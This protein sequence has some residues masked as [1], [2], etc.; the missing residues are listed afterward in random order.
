MISVYLLDMIK[1]NRL[2]VLILFP[3]SLFI[4]AAPSSAKIVSRN[5]T[6][7]T[8]AADEVLEED[9]FVAGE[10]ININGKVEG[11]LYAAGGVLNITGEVTGDILA[12]GGSITISA[13]TG[14]DIRVAGGN[15]IISGASIGD[16]LNVFGGNII[17]DN[18][19]VIGG[20]LI[21]AGGS[22]TT[23]ARSEEHTSELQ[24]HSFISYA[25]FC[26]KKKKHHILHTTN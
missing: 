21:F 18:D 6:S 3:L 17:V 4:F 16:S 2:L 26:L 22:I 20:S 11:D 12:T 9:L 25:V 15:I 7:Y 1:F 8:L 23:S 10:T 14:D 13:T 24:S 19:T 5:A